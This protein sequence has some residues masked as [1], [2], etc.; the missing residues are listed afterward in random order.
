MSVFLWYLVFNKR[1]SYILVCSVF[2]CFELGWANYGPGVVL[3]K[4]PNYLK[5]S[6]TWRLRLDVPGSW[7]AGSEAPGQKGA[8]TGVNTF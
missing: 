8:A 1:V 3:Q 4:L 2:L 7:L 5:L 6:F